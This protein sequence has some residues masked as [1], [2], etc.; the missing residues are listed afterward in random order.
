MGGSDSIQPADKKPNSG[1]CRQTIARRQRIERDI[2]CVGTS[3]G[4]GG[5]IDIECGI[6]CRSD[7]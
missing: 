7:K 1:A 6:A 4:V 2:V 3:G 5:N